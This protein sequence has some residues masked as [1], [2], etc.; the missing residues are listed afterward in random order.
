M[1]TNL[2]F[3]EYQEQS[4]RT[5]RAQGRDLKS[6]MV[7]LLGHD[8][9]SLIRP[10]ER[11]SPIPRAPSLCRPSHHGMIRIGIMQ[12]ADGEAPHTDLLLKER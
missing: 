12:V 5:D 2:T 11:Y 1:E 3:R 7:P 8:R 9:A 10:L 6:I 4:S